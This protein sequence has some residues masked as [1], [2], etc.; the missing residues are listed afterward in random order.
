MRQH[1]TQTGD[2][3][4]LMNS[5]AFDNSCSQK[6][7]LMADL[8]DAAQEDSIIIQQLAS[9]Q[10]LRAS[11]QAASQLNK[12][13]TRVQFETF[14]SSFDD[15]RDEKLVFKQIQRMEAEEL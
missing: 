2:T 8:D 6:D 4:R 5:S 14:D 13:D 10:N 7:N 15:K 1:R 3:Q 12:T 11:Q 9:T